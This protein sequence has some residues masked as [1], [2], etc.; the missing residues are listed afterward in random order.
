MTA[1]EPRYLD[2]YLHNQHLGWLCEAG[3]NTRFVASE[4]Y[5]SGAYRPTLSLSLTI[6][7]NEELT[8]EILRNQFDPA[9][10]SEQGVL[11]P[12]FA[13][14]LPEGEL[15]KRLAATRRDPRDRDDFGLLAA[16]GED[17]PGAVKVL[18]ANL[19]NLT[20]AARAYGVTGG[21]DNLEIGVPE[22]A[23][24]GAASLS[25]QQNKL[26]LST[27]RGGKRFALPMKGQL[28]DL[29]AKL[30]EPGDD[31]Q[32]FNEYAAMSLAS[33]AGV[34]TAVCRPLPVTQIALPE[35]VALLGDGL[36]FL[37]VDRYDRTPSGAVH[38]EDAC[39]AMTLQPHQ[40]YARRNLYVRLLR[41]LDRLSV[42]GVEDVRQF[43][44]RH[45]VNTLVGNSDAHLRNFSFIYH[46][47]VNPELSPAYD[48]VC[49]SALPGFA[50]YATNVAIDK[51]QREET[52]DTYRQMALDAGISP[53]I[54]VAAVKSAVEQAQATWGPL[55][56]EL[57]APVPVASVVRERLRTL[58][59]AN[60]WRAT[61]PKK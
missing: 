20:P 16:A 35:L 54:A 26:A 28:S 22:R 37:A 60:A 2:V 57:N 39:Q 61:S 29:V 56:D 41:V 48:I 18:P 9:L 40:K 15:R 51:L 30:P 14:L 17:L 21:A 38:V 42:R 5:Q 12:F 8:Q 11:P 7:G 44:I 53:K 47:G 24:E 31:S 33:R 45:A 49:V 36:H 59:L 4:A 50:G 1:L 32:V 6:P 55:L 34:N 27:V 25:G 23:A 46:N 10:Y 13:G 43:F 3:R 52:I 19:D 58:P